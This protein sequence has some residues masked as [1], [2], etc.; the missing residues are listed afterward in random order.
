M[1]MRYE[2]LL[3]GLEFALN[4]HGIDADANTADFTL[5]AKLAPQ[6]IHGAECAKRGLDPSMTAMLKTTVAHLDGTQ[7]V[8]VE[9]LG[10]GKPSD[11]EVIAERLAKVEDRLAK[12]ADDSARHDLQLYERVEK[13]EKQFDQF[14]QHMGGE[15]S[16]LHNRLDKVAEI[17]GERVSGLVDRMTAIENGDA[18]DYA[19]VL[20]GL[21][22]VRLRSGLGKMEF[23]HPRG[24]AFPT[25][26]A[27]TAEAATDAVLPV[28]QRGDR[29]RL[30]GARSVM[31]N[32]VVDGWHDVVGQTHT[33]AT[34]EFQIANLFTWIYASDP[35][36][37]E[38]ES[39]GRS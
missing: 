34:P 14:V 33:S 11:I 1:K 3:K 8:K 4:Y 35:G 12:D 36:L 30:E 25:G 9:P 23:E 37:K 22:E 15:T 16:G 39:N 29:V 28:P 20:K 18:Q 21:D 24:P 7:S 17:I 38:V 2:D 13:V 6:L 31:N 19:Y 5:A 27:G 26:G 10:L 32:P